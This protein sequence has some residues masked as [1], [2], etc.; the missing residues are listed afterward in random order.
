MSGGNGVLRTI[1]TGM[2]RNSRAATSRR[3]HPVRYRNAEPAPP[4]P[5]RALLGVA[6]DIIR[7][8][9]AG[10]STREIVVERPRFTAPGALAAT[11]FGHA[12]VLMEVDGL[13]I[14]ADPM[15]A[16]RASPVA[17]VGPRRL[18][19]APVSADDL[20]GID[21][22]VVSH[23]H[24]D[25][26]DRST[27]AQISSRTDAPILVPLG[28]GRY[29]RRWVQRPSLV[30]EMRWYDE[31]L[32]DGVRIACTP[33]RHFS[34]RGLARN[35]TLWSSWS[36]IGPHHRAFF[37]G[38]TGYTRA[39]AD[40]AARYGPFDL[41][42]LPIGAYDIAWPDVHMTP[43]EAIAAHRDLAGSTL[44]PIHWAT[45]NLARHPWAEPI[46]RLIAAAGPDVALAL[47][48]P[49]RRLD[50]GSNPVEPVIGP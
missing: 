20:P 9:H 4:V 38:D 7:N 42:V 33:A 29:V 12:S 45:F 32:I 19:P 23:D 26:F 49:G 37:G 13:S 5:A 17:F 50:F 47:P 40:I 25:H 31:V 11:W 18:H 15:F 30:I 48:P 43:E 10:S 27:L 21:A 39:F 6:R 28:L 36:L 44:L 8:R 1:R 22:I 46:E 2:A 16:D 34:G 35:T 41:T 24:Y 14:L 3:A